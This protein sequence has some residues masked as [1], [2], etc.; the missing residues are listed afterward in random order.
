M[1]ISGIASSAG[2]ELPNP[3]C[4]IVLKTLNN[5]ATSLMLHGLHPAGLIP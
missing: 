4:S 1:V 3:K 2:Y 5:L